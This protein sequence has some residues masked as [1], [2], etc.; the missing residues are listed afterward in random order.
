MRDRNES[1]NLAFVMVAPCLESF[2]AIRRVA[3]AGR[4]KEYFSRCSRNLTVG[5]F[6]V[7]QLPPYDA[8]IIKCLNSFIVITNRFPVRSKVNDFFSLGDATY[9]QIKNDFAPSRIWDTKDEIN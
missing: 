8:D 4:E 7:L 9:D 6:T 1:G 2:G 5:D 3:K